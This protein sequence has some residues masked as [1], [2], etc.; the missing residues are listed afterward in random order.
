MAKRSAARRVV[1]A[2]GIDRFGALPPVLAQLPRELASHSCDYGPLDVFAGREVAVVGAGQSALEFAALLHE[3]GASVELI[4]RGHQT[5]FLR[6]KRLREFFGPLSWIVYPPEDVGPPGIN[7]LTAR[8]NLLRRLPR[9]TQIAIGRRAIKPA[10][11]VWVQPRVTGIPVTLNVEI[12]SAEEVDGRVRLRLSDGSERTVDHVLAAT[13][14]QVDLAKYPFIS[15]PL[16]RQVTV[17]NGG[18]PVLGNGFETSVPGLHVVGAPAAWSYGPL[19]R[20]VSG[21]WFASRTL[22]Q[23]IAG[24]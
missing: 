2:A 16:L 3:A 15:E 5:R 11:A 4:V 9:S 7:L 18:Y 20:F 21:T 10:G 12:T 6:G 23:R 17:V 13:G 14:F 24:R 1:V 19:M 22:A 8:P